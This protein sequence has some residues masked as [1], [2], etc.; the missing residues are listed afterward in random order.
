[1]CSTTPLGS[2]VCLQEC[3]QNHKPS[4]LSWCLCLD[5]KRLDTQMRLV[6]SYLHVSI[7]CIYCKTILK[8]PFQ[9]ILY[10]ALM[11]AV[12][13]QHSYTPDNTS[14]P[15]LSYRFVYETE[16]FNGVG[17]LLEILGRWVLTEFRLHSFYIYGDKIM[18]VICKHIFN[19][20][21]TLILQLQP[22]SHLHSPN[23]L[24][25]LFQYN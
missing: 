1:M 18:F 23:L 5:R 7:L 21:K 24:T 16:H 4:R 6:S 20:L 3:N 9:Y 12:I 11:N 25:Y 19:M 14:Y 13:F 10:S 2:L 8:F 17:E 15:S 22:L